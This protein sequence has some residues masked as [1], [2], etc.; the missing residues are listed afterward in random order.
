MKKILSIVAV[1]MFAFSC[2]AQQINLGPNSPIQVKGVLQQFYGGTGTNVSI[3]NCHASNQALIWNPSASPAQFQCNTFAIGVGSVTNVSPS[4]TNPMFV[5]SVANQST[6]PQI[7]ITLSDALNQI[8]VGSGAGAGSWTTVPNCSG[9]TNAL[10]Y[11]NSTQTFT[12]LSIS[13]GSLANSVVFAASGG[14]SAGTS[15][16][17]ASPVTVDYHTVGAPS[18]SGTG[19]SGTWG[20]NISGQSGSVANSVTFNSS[21]AGGSS[22]QVYNGSS[23]FTVSYNTIGAPST[24]GTGA[25]GSWSINAATA[26]ALASPPTTCSI[27]QWAT[28]IAATGNAICGASNVTITLDS[29]SPI[30]ATTCATG[31]TQALTGVRATSAFDTGFG[32]DPRAVAGWGANGGLVVEIWPDASNDIFD[33]AVCNQSNSSIT[34]GAMTLNVGVK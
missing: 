23:A 12:C 14:A 10:N 24:T 31:H 29:G 33:W 7:S 4:G 2:A 8:F 25:S 11:N 19:A 21:G 3:P 32:S 16:N 9:G 13:T 17:G 20:I 27:G 1:L 15:F 26:T 5:L 22:P 34:P 28:G 18:A 6:T 30:T